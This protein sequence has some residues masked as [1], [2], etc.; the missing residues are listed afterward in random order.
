[1]NPF[2]DPGACTVCGGE[3][4]RGN[5]LTTMQQSDL[6]DVPGNMSPSLEA[7]DISQLFPRDQL[8]SLMTPPPP[9]A[10][11]DIGALTRF[12][13]Q[14]PIAQQWS[15]LAFTH[16]QVALDEAACTGPLGKSTEQ[17]LAP[18]S[19]CA[20]RKNNEAKQSPP[21]CTIGTTAATP[22]SIQK[23]LNREKELEAQLNEKNTT[24]CYT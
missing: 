21:S 18:S 12:S 16:L 11:R 5:R 1:V 22:A 8:E 13:R 3:Q 23:Q 24:D 9:Y 14:N 15:T 19:A 20:F 2:E 17:E 4:P 10:L 7:H 6:L